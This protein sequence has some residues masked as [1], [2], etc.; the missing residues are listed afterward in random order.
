MP[1]LPEVETI[2]QGLEQRLTGR[3]I[4]S[5]RI[6]PDR[7][8]PVPVIKKMDESTFREGVVGA[9]VEGVSRRG[10]Y[11]VLHLDTNRMLVIHL[12][13]TGALLFPEAPEDRFVRAIFSFDDGTEMRFTD[14]RKFGGLWLADDLSEVTTDLGPEPLSE[15]FT[16]AS[17]AAAVAKRKAPVKSIILDQRR[18]AGI[19]N[20]YA[21]EACFGAGIDPRRLGMTLSEEEVL[22]LHASIRTALMAGLD[23]G[24][25]SFRDYRNTGGDVGSMQQH[26]KVFRRTGKPCYTCETVI[27]RVKVGGRSTHFCPKCQR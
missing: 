17:L 14:V 15:G 12:R 6:P 26:V 3:T 11:L 16:L 24:G 19:G 2:R 20:I 1:E 22:A 13:M 8:K 5:L 23:H 21:D 7:G 27:E 18:I 10:K 25:A 4:T 9:R